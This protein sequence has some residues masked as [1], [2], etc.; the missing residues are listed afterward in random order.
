MVFSSKGRHRKA[1]TQV[2]SPASRV[3]RRRR[4][5]VQLG[6]LAASVGVGVATTA[7]VGGNTRIG[8]SG[9]GGSDNGESARLP[10]SIKDASHDTGTGSMTTVLLVFPDHF[11]FRPDEI[12][13]AVLG[14]APWAPD[15][16]GYVDPVRGTFHPTG[17][18]ADFRLD[19]ATMTFSVS[20]LRRDGGQSLTLTIPPLAS[21]RVYFAFGRGFDAMPPF[22]AGG[23]S[24]GAD[25]PVLYDKFE[26]HTADHPNFKLT[27]ADFWSVPF[28]ISAIDANTG[29]R[30]VVGYPHR[31]ADM[32]AAFDSIPVPDAAEPFGNPSIF[33]ALRVSANDGRLTRILSPKQAR[34]TDWGRDDATRLALAQRFTHFWDRYVNELCWRP[35]RLFS[36]YGKDLTDKRVFYGRVAP[37]GM[38]LSLFTDAAYTVPYRVPTLP[39]PSARWGQPDYSPADGNPSLF[40]N[41]DSSVGPIDWGFL[42]AGNAGAQAGDGAHWAS[43]PAAIAIAM[44]ICRGVMHLDDGCVSWIDPARFYNGA[45]DGV[46]TPRMPIFWYAKLLHAFGID[47]RAYAFSYDDVYGTDPAVYFGSHSELIVQFGQM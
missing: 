9:G 32:I 23:P 12:F 44:S 26:L 34:F 8:G 25:N 45:G 15:V 3:D 14:R 35:N 33:K 27:N 31:R 39:R 41:T 4:S 42:L 19:S 40:H 17:S 36:F 1:G 10:V 11:S 6:A 13:V 38:T 22:G 29:T 46:D 24:N 2:A 30:R 16:F 21:G 18:A 47:A 7:L 43:D 28:T 20:T 37:D 5:V